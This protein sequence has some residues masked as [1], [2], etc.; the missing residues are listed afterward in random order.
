MS[1]IYYQTKLCIILKSIM[2]IFCSVWFLVIPLLFGEEVLG[3]L[4]VTFGKVATEG[5]HWSVKELF[6]NASVRLRID[7]FH[8]VMIKAELILKFIFCTLSLV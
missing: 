5:I 4:N 6:V 3:V 1:V 2:H 7:H 8:W